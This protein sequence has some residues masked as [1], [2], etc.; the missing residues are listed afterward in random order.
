LASAGKRSISVNLKHGEGAAIGTR[1]AQSTGILT[2]VKQVKINVPLVVRLEGTNVELGKQMLRDSK[3]NF[4][5]A[6]TMGEAAEKVV[7]L[8]K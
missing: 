6:D 1:L 2:A 5:T 7:T 3:L 8:A 4:T